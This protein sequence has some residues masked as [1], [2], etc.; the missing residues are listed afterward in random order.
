MMQVDY[1]YVAIICEQFDS[2]IELNSKQ[3]A[4]L[5][6]VYRVIEESGRRKKSAQGR[7]WAHPAQGSIGIEND[8][9]VIAASRSVENIIITQAGAARPGLNFGRIVVA[10]ALIVESGGRDRGDSLL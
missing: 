7:Q 10:A 3:L 5:C 9:R 8:R 4:G 2:A 1:T 6:Q